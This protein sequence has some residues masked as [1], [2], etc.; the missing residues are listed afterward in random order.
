MTYSD[1][2]NGASIMP[3]TVASTSGGTTANL[4]GSSDG[5]PAHGTISLAFSNVKTESFLR[6]TRSA[7]NLRVA[8]EPDPN[9]AS[10]KV[11]NNGTKK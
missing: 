9:D 5:S 6:K 2:Q 7:V 4:S 8:P 10:R 1:N 3:S 11:S